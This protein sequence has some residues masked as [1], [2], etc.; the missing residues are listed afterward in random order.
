[1]KFGDLI[2]GTITRFDDKGRGVFDL[3]RPNAPT[4]PVAV[5]FTTIGDV[6]EAKFIKRDKGVFVTDLIRVITPGPD[7]V[8]SPSPALEQ[9]SGGIW[10]NIAYDAQVNF[11]RERINAAF[12]AAGHDE[13]VENVTPSSVTTHFRNRMDFAV[14][15]DGKI[16]L[17]E[18][19][20]WSRY[21]DITEDPL[22]S[23]TTPRILDVIRRMIRKDPAV[24]QL[25]PWN[26]DA[27]V[28]DL[29]YVVIREGKNTK[30]RTVA[31][32]VKDLSRI[33]DDAKEYL[34]RELDALATGIVI[35]ENPLITDLSI[36]QTILPLK[37]DGTFKETV[38]GTTYRIH[39][40]SFFQTNSV[41]AATLQD[42]VAKLVLA[43]SPSKVLDLYC[44][45]GFFGINLAQ[46]D[47]NLNIS[48]FEIDAKAIELAK[49]NA[50]TNGVADRCEFASGPAEDLSWKEVNADVVILDPPRA[51]LHPRVVKTVLEK[52]PPIIVYVSC[53]YHR[54]VDEL[55]QFK[56]AYT[57]ESVQAVDMFPHSPHV[58]VVTKL[59]LK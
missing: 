18:F 30:E 31:L 13:R 17:K 23:D 49:E 8:P 24:P 47:K 36:A 3:E 37:G 34:R 9:F 2:Q 14:S 4:R 53:N 43:S 26:N 5:P 32:I 58:E 6:V 11:K 25:I 27:Y 7:R 39:L 55:K 52:K 15:W 29:R 59:I 35:G 28:G 16:G 38:N 19:G 41:M 12:E 57:V 56:T 51:G 50:E 42:E 1:M 44:G 45:L 54:L 20:S 22:L 33:S 40:N 10:M 21:R 46:R 48:G